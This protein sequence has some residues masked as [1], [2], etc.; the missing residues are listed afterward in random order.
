MNSNNESKLGSGC[1]AILTA[2]LACLTLA[3]CEEESGAAPPGNELDGPSFGL[4]GGSSGDSPSRVGAGN[5]AGT[6][7]VSCHLTA[8]T[9]EEQT[10]A[11]SHRR[12]WGYTY[13]PQG[14]IAKAV[15]YDQSGFERVVS[16]VIG[17]NS[18]SHSSE[19]GSGLTKYSVPVFSTAFVKPAGSK[20]DVTLPG[21]AP[22][23]DYRVREFEYDAKNRLIRMRESIPSVPRAWPSVWELTW[24]TND[25]IKTVQVYLVEDGTPNPSPVYTVTGYDDK[26]AP[27]TAAPYFFY[28]DLRLTVLDV[29]VSLSRNSPLGYTLD[30][31][32]PESVTLTYQ[33]NT[34]GYPL[35]R[36]GT[37]SSGISH[38]ATFAYDCNR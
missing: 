23:I 31:A 24:D 25:N 36:R 14:V 30:G 18:F 13:G 4:D 33:Y 8:E 6:S 16:E 11:S 9:Y 20:M 34:E 27:R 7:P 2:I 38:A 15:E 19:W 10:N 22:L 12:R 26:P 5:E 17:L 1:V 32:N 28:L 21:G 35:E 37:S 3:G 29:I